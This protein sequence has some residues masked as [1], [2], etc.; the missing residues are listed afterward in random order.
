MEA[1]ENATDSAKTGA[2][3]CSQYDTHYYNI[4]VTLAV[5]TASLSFIACSVVIVL[6]FALKKHQFLSQRLILY[7]TLAVMI[8]CLAWGPQKVQYELV[9]RYDIASE[10]TDR[11]C[12]WAGYFLL[13]AGWFE[14]MAVAILTINLFLHAVVTRAKGWLELVYVLLIFLL[15]FAFT[16]IPFTQD[17]YGQAALRCWIRKEDENCEKLKFEIISFTIWYVPL[18]LLLFVL[19][20]VY[21]VVLCQ[22]SKQNTWDG[23]FNPM[24]RRL[25]L[26][27]KK[28]V[29]P[30]IWYPMIYF[31]LHLIPLAAHISGAL[32]SKPLYPLWVLT[33]ITLPLQGGFIALAFTLDTKTLRRLRRQRIRGTVRG[34]A[35]SNNVEEYPTEQVRAEQWNTESTTSSSD[36][37]EDENEEGEKASRRRG[38]YTEFTRRS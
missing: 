33:A 19:V 10:T 1:L 28:D 11:L 17:A 8:K 16:W 5:S 27:M 30:L 7:L 23:N 12:S 14:L 31:L 37:H 25:K 36:E 26:K 35:Q 32:R 24:L 4:I 29:R 2:T 38:R 22:I 9:H 15:P 6:I 13:T 21:G 20:I 18:Y 3:N 34:I